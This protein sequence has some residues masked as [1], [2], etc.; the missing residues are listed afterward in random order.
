MTQCIEPPL[1]IK[2]LTVLHHRFRR[3]F[4]EPAPS[5][6]E[7]S[8]QYRLAAVAAVRTLYGTPTPSGLFLLIDEA[9]QIGVHPDDL[10]NFIGQQ[11][12]LTP[13]R[14]SVGSKSC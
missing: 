6:M 5:P 4:G 13:M 3:L 9:G 7:P 14:R 1:T 10:A 8:R 11:F 2:S 12:K